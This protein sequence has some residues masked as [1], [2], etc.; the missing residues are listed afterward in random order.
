M[1]A[2]SR[3]DARLLRL[4]GPIVYLASLLGLLL[5]LV[6]GTTINGAHAWI[7]L[8][9]GFELQPSEFMKLGLIV[10]MAV[11]FTQRAAR[12]EEQ[13][14][15]ADPTPST[16]DVLLAIGL[17]AVPLGAD[18]AA[19]RPRLGD[20]ARLRRVRRADRG[21]RA[22]ALDGRAHPA[23]R[24][25][26]PS[27][28]SR[29]ASC[30]ATSSTGSSPSPTRITTCRAR[31][32]TSPRRTSPSP[33][34]GCSGTG[35]FHG[36]QT[37]GGFV[38]EQQ[39]DFIF[40]VAGEEFGLVGGGVDHRA[41]RAAVLARA[42]HRPRRRRRRPAARRRHRVLVRVPGLPEHRHEPR[43]DAGDR[44][45]AAVRLLR[46]LVD[47]RAGPGDRAAAGRPPA[48]R[49]PEA[50][51]RLR[52]R[53]PRHHG[54]ARGRGSCPTLAA[55]TI[56][57]ATTRTAVS[58]WP[59]TTTPASAATAGSRLISSPKTAVDS[60][61]SAMSSSVYGISDDSRATPRQAPSTPGCQSAAPPSTRPAG[62]TRN[63][64]TAM[65]IASASVAAND[66]ADP[67]GQQDVRRPSTS[68]RSSARTTPEH[69]H[70]ALLAAQRQQDHPAGREQHPQ[71]RRAAGASRPRPA[72]AGR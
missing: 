10:G 15:D 1:L 33:T 12:R 28:R 14:P 24:R 6:A 34:A 25:R 23:R 36:P 55:T 19:A 63:V 31:P 39:T 70:A 45:A 16:G 18:H 32:T 42:A 30:T 9:G 22:G 47:V 53:G 35:L 51:S 4:F 50:P 29:A 46:R 65:P 68:P 13:S 3:L 71:R 37:N 8:G 41:V 54:A 60:R 62:S 44:R 64:P 69:L 49:Q 67:L 5:V 17:I 56:A 26:S 66:F 57:S 38:P 72:R 58:D 40:S 21:R 43:P 52:P 11:L 7:R 61:R 2:A 48:Q 27:S 59:S 20:G